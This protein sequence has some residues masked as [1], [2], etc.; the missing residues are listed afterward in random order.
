MD[1]T[2]LSASGPRVLAPAALV[3]LLLAVSL[4]LYVIDQATKYLVW[5]YIGLNDSI[6]V[7]PRWFDLV[8]VTNTGAA[9]GMMHNSNWFFAILSLLAVVVL[10]VLYRQGAFKE[11]LSLA[12]FLL[13]VPGVLGN[14]TD[15]LAHGHV[16]D[17]LSFDLHLPGASPWPS[18]NV[19][20]SCICVAVGLFQISSFQDMR[21]ES[22]GRRNAD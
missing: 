19:A 8:H 9:W 20:D 22:A 5:R 16:I 15:R 3:R 17:F 11:L 7:V 13:L 12:G 21:R 1:S 18:F 4:P 6:A 2:I 14:L 10:A